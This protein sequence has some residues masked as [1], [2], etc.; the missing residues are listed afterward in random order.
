[1]SDA[2]TNT[3]SPLSITASI[4]GIL[5]FLA[6]ILAAVWLRISSLRSADTEYFRV[7]TA[8]SWYKTE[9]EWINDLIATQRNFRNRGRSSFDSYFLRGVD[10]GFVEPPSPGMGEGLHGKG[11]DRERERER[12]TEMYL[13]VLDQLGTLE[14]R[15]LEVVT[16]VEVKAERTGGQGEEKGSGRWT[17]VPRR[18]GV[19]TE[20]AVQWLPVRTKALELVRQREALGSR[21]L[22]A[23]LAMISS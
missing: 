3:D 12:E 17:F 10:S 15:L 18:W 5:T 14:E 13:F 6:A 16:G 19:R 21:V 22:F 1:M 8:L 7:K 23:Q 9:S 20:I 4:T 2:N 11:R